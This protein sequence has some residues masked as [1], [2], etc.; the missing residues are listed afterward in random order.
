MSP[1]EVPTLLPME[2]IVTLESGQTTNRALQVC[3]RHHLVPLKLVLLC[4]GEKHLVKLQ[5]NIGNFIKPLPMDIEA[6][7]NKE[8]Q[9]RGMFEYVKGLVP[10]TFIYLHVILGLSFLFVFFFTP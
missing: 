10:R 8:S 4:N 2:E 7:L 3:F 6:F 9:L 5:P 1:V